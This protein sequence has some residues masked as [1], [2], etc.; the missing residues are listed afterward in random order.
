[1]MMQNRQGQTMQPNR[2]PMGGG[3]WG[4]MG[5]PVEKPKTFK[6]TAL[7]LMR[8][9]LPQKFLLMMVLIAA[10]IGTVFNIVGPKILGLAITKLADGL[11]AKIRF[12]FT[13]HPPTAVAPGVDFGYIGT[14]LLI[15]LWLYFISSICFILFWRVVLILYISFPTRLMIMPRL[16]QFKNFIGGGER[17]LYTSV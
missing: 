8:Y 10:I 14:V 6:A 17:F 7:R 3:A 12:Q 9:F 1:M 4:A 16:R 11:I 2:G 15:L 13:P 5:R